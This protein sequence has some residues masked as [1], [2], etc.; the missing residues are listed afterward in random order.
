LLVLFLLGLGPIWK[1]PWIWA[2]F[3]L[4]YIAQSYVTDRTREN[5]L[6]WFMLAVLFAMAWVRR[7]EKFAIAWWSLLLVV[8]LHSVHRSIAKPIV[9]YLCQL[10]AEDKYHRLVVLIP[11]VQPK[12]FWYYLLFNQRGVILDRAI[13][14]G[15]ANVLLCR[16]EQLTPPPG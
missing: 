1:K 4:I 9:K 13:R 6:P 2:S 12:K 15:T 3:A 10:E 16:L 5:V 11:E 14:R 7:R 8:T